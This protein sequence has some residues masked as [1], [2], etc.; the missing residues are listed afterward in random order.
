MRAVC[1]VLAA[2]LMTIPASAQ[3]E[4]NVTAGAH[5]VRSHDANVFGQ[6]IHYV[7]AGQG[8][9]VV[10]LHAL[11]AD[12]TDWRDNIA[13]LAAAHRVIAFDSVG[14]GQSDKPPIDYRPSTMI[15]FLAGFMDALG[16]QRASL[17]G[18]SFSG[19]TAA[20]FALAF[21]HRVD[22]LVLVASGYG[23]SL[24]AASSVDRLGF[25]PGTLKYI[26]PSNL[27]ETRELIRL[28]IADPAKANDESAVKNAFAQA[29]RAGYL[30]NRIRVTFVNRTETLDGRLG[31]LRVPTLVIW[32]RKD[33]ITPFA[34]GERFR[35]EIPGARLL[36]FDASSHFPNQEEA[37]AFNA[38][39][40]RFLDDQ[41]I[42]NANSSPRSP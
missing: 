4:S 40:A 16:I 35:S 38:A 1:L 19:A 14:S 15:D 37:P 2:C 18:H 21:P 6:R 42:G 20:G 13:A 24:P 10:L 25:V 34:M 8:P 33:G 36:A 27:A 29:L 28:T 22:R 11:G 32:G 41:A 30:M 5:D 3:A 9:P 26:F 31:A 7:E 23:Y 39:V 17:V 12:L